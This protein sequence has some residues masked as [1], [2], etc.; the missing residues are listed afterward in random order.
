MYVGTQVAARNDA[1]FE[2]WAQLGVMNVCSDP[3][4]NPHDWTIDDLKRHRE[5]VNSYGIELDMVQIPLSSRVLDESQSPHI[6]QGISPE[7]DREI[8]SIQNIIRMCGQVGIPAV[9]YNMNIIGIPRSEREEGRGGASASTFR[10]AKMDQDAPPTIAGE[11]SVDEFWERI[12]YFLE[13]VVPVAE[14]T[15]VRLACHPHDPYTPDGYMGVTR[16]LG[17]VEGL[18]KFVMMHE[19]DY[20]GLNFCQGTVTEMLDDPG[21]EIADVI[22]WFGSRNKI[23]NVHFRNIR[24]H[25]LDFMESFPD[26]GSID[27]SE[28]IK[29]YQEVGY[30]YMLMPDHVPWISGDDPQGT[31]F[32]F[33]YG[34]ISAL[35]QTINEPR[36]QPWVTKEPGV[37]KAASNQG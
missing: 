34:Y 32:A 36:K 9:K 23:F 24:G 4:G 31:A 8:E 26:E 6:M 16:V 33:C 11:V 20:H 35:L 21:A 28:I 17:T 18:K 19:S 37:H 13:R 12:D 27:F 29:V 25:K 5:K 3:P 1:D 7:R 30:K 2:Q 10:W 15:K 22:R 14:K